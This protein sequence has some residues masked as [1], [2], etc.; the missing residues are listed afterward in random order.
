MLGGIINDYYRASSGTALAV[1]LALLLSEIIFKIF[2]PTVPKR[3]FSHH[4]NALLQSCHSQ[5]QTLEH[6]SWP[7]GDGKAA[8]SDQFLADMVLLGTV[9]S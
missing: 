6:P 8:I 2:S 3:A 1:S 9:Y 5:I 7:Q 4:L